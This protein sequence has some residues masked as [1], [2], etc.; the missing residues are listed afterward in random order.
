MRTAG[1]QNKSSY[2]WRVTEYLDDTKDQPIKMNIYK[3]VKEVQEVYGG[4]TQQRVC[5]FLRNKSIGEKGKSKD[6]FRKILIEKINIPCGIIR[7]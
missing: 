2:K 6:I 4:L 5:D 1:S 3:S 7:I